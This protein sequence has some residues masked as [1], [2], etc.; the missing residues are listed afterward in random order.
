[1]KPIREVCAL[2][3]EGALKNEIIATLKSKDWSDS[4][5]EINELVKQIKN[6]TTDNLPASSP[7]TAISHIV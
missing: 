7:P 4:D 1:M 5:V 2:I 3:I 6:N